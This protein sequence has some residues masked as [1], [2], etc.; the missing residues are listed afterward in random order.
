[1]WSPQIRFL[2]GKWYIYYTASDGKNDNHRMFVLEAESQNTLG[3]YC[4]KSRIY[5]ARHDT[6]GIFGDV[7]EH[8]GKFYALWSAWERSGDQF[9]QHTFIAPM[10]NP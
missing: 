3:A 5:D 2:Q 9:P 10:S 7:L 4:E 1:M 6:W 8:N